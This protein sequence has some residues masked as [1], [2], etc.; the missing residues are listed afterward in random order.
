MAFAGS[1]MIRNN[2][3]IRFIC[4][5]TKH[6]VMPTAI[7]DCYTDEPAGLGVPPYLGTYPRYLYG[8]LKQQKKES[9]YF[10]IDD[11][12]LWKK[13]HGRDPNKDLKKSQ[14]TNNTVY[15]LT[16]HHQEIAG[17]L[18]NAEELIIILGVHVPGKYLSAM[19][20]TIHEITALLKDVTCKKILTGPAIFG[21][22]LFGGKRSES[23]LG[24]ETRQYNFTFDEIKEY[25][26]AGA[27]LTQQIPWLKIIEIETARGCIRI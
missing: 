25:A 11:L 5:Y 18:H 22:Q 3:T 23:I 2:K 10:T 27:E 20:G 4:N 19:P 15:N 13:Y 8:C 12:R 7:L 24:F 17:I 6:V 9:F 1:L 21:T 14:T 26:I 16:K